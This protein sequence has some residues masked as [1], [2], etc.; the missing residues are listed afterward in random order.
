MIIKELTSKCL[1]KVIVELKK[2]E[3]MSKIRKELMDPLIHYTYKRIYPYFL[4]TIVIF[5]L[6]FILALLIFIILVKKILRSD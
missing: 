1:E 4:I 6:T 2:E 5:L 3:N